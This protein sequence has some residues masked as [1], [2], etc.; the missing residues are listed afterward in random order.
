MWAIVQVNRYQSCRDSGELR[1]AFVSCGT[2]RDVQC[3]Q[4]HEV[5]W[6]HVHGTL[7]LVVAYQIAIEAIHLTGTVTLDVEHS[8]QNKHFIQ[9]SRLPLTPTGWN[10]LWFRHNHEDRDYERMHIASDYLLPVFLFLQ[11]TAPYIHV[12][13]CISAED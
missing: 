4:S 2:R 10:R 6:E 9:K 3:A 12:R 1:I 5:R 7:P 13:V 11:S 8:V